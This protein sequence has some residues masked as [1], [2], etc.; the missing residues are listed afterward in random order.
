MSGMSQFLRAARPLALLT[1]ALALMLVC[2]PSGASAQ[3]LDLESA[4]EIL[5]TARNNSVIAGAPAEIQ[6]DDAEWH[7]SVGVEHATAQVRQL[8]D[9]DADGLHFYVL[10]K[11][12]A[13]RAIL[14]SLEGQ[15]EHVPPGS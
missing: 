3:G 1:C 8:V 14:S 5:L 2:A 6:S 12:R 9:H 7:Y 11:S 10:N 13:A 15:F 4:T